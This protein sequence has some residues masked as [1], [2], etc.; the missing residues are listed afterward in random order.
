MSQLCKITLDGSQIDANL[1]RIIN[2]FS[3]RVDAALYKRCERIMTRS[4]ESFVPVDFGTLKNSGIV[5]PPER[6]GKSIIVTLA[7][8]GAAEAYAL[9]IHE[10]LSSHSPPSWRGVT[11]HFHPSGRGPKYLEKPLMEATKTLA[12]DLG[13][14]L[15]LGTI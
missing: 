1:R 15:H 8:G 2:S 3:L 5:L 14:D 6:K 12:A 4:K 10:H 9:A 7:Y 13:S 11:V